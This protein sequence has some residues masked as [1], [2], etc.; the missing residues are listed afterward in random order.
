MLTGPHQDLK[1]YYASA[2]YY[3]DKTS[4]DLINF[5]EKKE[6]INRGGEHL[7]KNK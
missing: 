1:S 6:L 2:N 3:S 7:R 4:I 5:Q